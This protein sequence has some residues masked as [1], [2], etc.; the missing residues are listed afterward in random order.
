MVTV[1]VQAAPP[2]APACPPRSEALVS[3]EAA[4]PQP[5]PPRAPPGRS[6]PVSP[7]AR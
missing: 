5:R 3:T 1:Q 4:S 7:Q 6:V 2:W